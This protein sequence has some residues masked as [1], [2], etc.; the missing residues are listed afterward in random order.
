MST[1]AVSEEGSGRLE[2][3]S[4]TAT[5]GAHPKS[6]RAVRE[7]PSLPQEGASLTARGGKLVEQGRTY[8]HLVAKLKPTAMKAIPTTRFH[9]P[10]SLK[11]HRLERSSEKT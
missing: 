5:Q 9:W 3:A 2:P 6:T 1:G 8:S 7:T 11:S 10:R 4:H